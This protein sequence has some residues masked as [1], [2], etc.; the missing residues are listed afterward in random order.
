MSKVKQKKKLT[1]KHDAVVARIDPEFDEIRYGGTSSRHQRVECSLVRQ[2]SDS[3]PGRQPSHHY[4]HYYNDSEKMRHIDRT[5]RI[6][7][8]WLTQQFGFFNMV[9]WH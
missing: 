8:G 2:V 3:V 5:Q 9:S 1:P 6:S 4:Y 7:F